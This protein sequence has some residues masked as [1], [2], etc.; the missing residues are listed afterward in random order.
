VVEGLR[1]ERIAGPVMEPV[2]GASRV[3]LHGRMAGGSVT[4]SPVIEVVLRLASAL[5]P[6]LHPLTGQPI[7]A[8]VSVTLRGL[9]DFTPKPWPDRFRELHERGGRLEVTQARAR[10]GEVVATGAGSLG[11]TADGNLDG[12]LQVTVAGLEQVLRTLRLDQPGA[13][14]EGL[15]Q[16]NSALAKLDGIV[17]GLGNLARQQAGP[18][19]AA[20]LGLIGSRTTLEGRD[21]L[22]LPLRFA[23]GRVFL[24][25]VVLGYTP[26]LF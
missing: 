9:K 19:L 2:L 8:D 20:G 11:L 22:A 14:R 24:G 1:L 25:P 10:Q 23:G 12:Q 7:D 5:A 21:A 26:R 15:E 13:Q 3:E 4:D 17:P 18:A 16:L 6:T